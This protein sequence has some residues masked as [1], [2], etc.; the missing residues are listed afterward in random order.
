MRNHSTKTSWSITNLSRQRAAWIAGIALL[1]MAVLAPIAQ[2]GVLENLI[3]PED[4][5]T[6]VSNI[7][8]SPG[9]FQIAG[10]AF[11]IVALL[12]VVVA[13]T[14]HVVLQGVN[15]FASLVTAWL[16]TVYAGVLAIA[17]TNLFEVARVATDR[18]SLDASGLQ[19]EVIGSLRSFHIGYEEIGLAIFALHLFGLGYLV[20]RSADFPRFLGILVVVA[21]GGYL[22]DSL[23]QMLTAD[24]GQSVAQFTFVGEALLIFWLFWRAAKGFPTVESP[25]EAISRRVTRTASL[26][27]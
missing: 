7:V 20:Y 3:V 6:T 13:W 10:V 16:R 1:L 2:F 22:F 15:R 11:V 17:T 12:D 9:M 8:A 18:A 23:G 5:S 24:F 19:T 14:L 21:G 25:D 26:N 27:R 4:A